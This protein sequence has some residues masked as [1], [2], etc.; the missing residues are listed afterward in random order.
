LLFVHIIN[1]RPLNLP[2]ASLILTQKSTF[3]PKKLTSSWRNDNQ[4]GLQ[5][6]PSDIQDRKLILKSS[7]SGKEREIVFILQKVADRLR[8]YVISRETGFDQ[9]I[10]PI[11]YTAGRRVLNKAGKVVGNH[12]RPLKG[13]DSLPRCA[14][15]KRPRYEKQI[16]ILDLFRLLTLIMLRG[17]E[18][19]K[20]NIPASNPYGRITHFNWSHIPN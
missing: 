1:R 10:F 3:Q 13:L 4:E 7:K 11:S 6:T 19:R 18:K 16:T 12:L 2:E 15:F 20:S 14:V 5:L 8:E 9:R 17:A